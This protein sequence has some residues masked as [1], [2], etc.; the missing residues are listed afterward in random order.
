[1]HGELRWGIAE[2]VP[3]AENVDQ[4]IADDIRWMVEDADAGCSGWDLLAE[5][6]AMVIE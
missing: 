4:Y 3:T 2:D 1:M 5:I 6:A